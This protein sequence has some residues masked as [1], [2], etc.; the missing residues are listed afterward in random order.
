[1]RIGVGNGLGV[2]GVDAVS[3][4]S[5]YASDVYHLDAAL[6]VTKDGSNRVS[7]WVDQSK[8]VTIS[9]G[10]V[11]NEPLWVA[12]ATPA[13]LPAMHLDATNRF[14]TG[15][16][17]DLFS[18]SSLTLVA[19]VK[20]IA[21]TKWWVRSNSGQS[22][23]TSHALGAAS[24]LTT[25]TGKNSATATAG[26]QDTSAFRVFAWSLAAS[27]FGGA[28]TTKQCLINGVAATITGTPSFPDAPG[29]SGALRM[30]T[31][32]VSGGQIA[33]L[34]WCEGRLLDVVTLSRIFG[35]KHG[36]SVA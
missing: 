28:L 21:A 19:V 30:G 7:A 14:F 26:A 23:A 6:G 3:L 36:I 5:F 4:G 17:A 16:L 22:A 33:D 18:S 29:A 2:T 12:S 24:G 10:G 15:T 13:G 32:G 11:G 8:A 27:S 1:M 9:R 31:N 20:E 25:Y 34:L 35:A